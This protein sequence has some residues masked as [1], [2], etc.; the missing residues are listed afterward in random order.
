M[1]LSLVL[2]FPD[3]TVTRRLKAKKEDFSQQAA[4]LMAMKV[5]DPL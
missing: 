5:E 1:N 2:T 3:D 4:G